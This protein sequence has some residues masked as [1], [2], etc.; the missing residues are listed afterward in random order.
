MAKNKLAIS[1]ERSCIYQLSLYRS[2]AVTKCPKSTVSN[3]QDF[4]WNIWFFGTE[5]RDF[6]PRFL[7]DQTWG[8]PV[9]AEL[10]QLHSIKGAILSSGLVKSSTLP[11]VRRAQNLSHRVWKQRMVKIIWCHLEFTKEFVHLFCLR[12]DSIF[13]NGRIFSFWRDRTWK[14]LRSYNIKR[15]CFYHFPASTLSGCSSLRS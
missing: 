2:W 7:G 1:G 11:T 13:Q 14:F 4:W 15:R 12:M 3:C 5:V 8:W 6:V 9:E 10:G